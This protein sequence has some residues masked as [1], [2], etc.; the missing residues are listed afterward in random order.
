MSAPPPPPLPR[1]VAT[2]LDGTLLDAQGR[3]TPRTREV[4]K[5]LEDLGVPTVFVTGRPVRWMETLWEEVGD[6]GLAIC[7]NGAVVYDVAR[8]VVRDTRP[9]AAATVLAI[10]DAV[11]AVEPHAR[12]AVERLDGMAHEPDFVKDPERFRPTAVGAL[13]ELLDGP[14]V[15][16]VLVRHPDADPETFWRAVEGA[17]AGL[18]TVTW[19]SVG[20]LVEISADG[21]TKATTL[22]LLCAD[23]G[24]AADEVVAFGDMPNDVPLLAWAG[25]SY[26]MA[27]A[28]PTARAVAGGLAG[29]HDEDG[30]AEVLAGIFGLGA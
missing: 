5:A 21:V 10:A 16:K 7:S 22:A 11:R 19:S 27:D 15:V 26:A 20:A 4:L 6:V 18:A 23:L 14:D 17:C 9:V 24:V 25:R 30:V 28:H 3:V 8:H 12:F 1:L 2:D 29:P 13:P